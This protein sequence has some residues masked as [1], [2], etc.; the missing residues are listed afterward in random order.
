MLKRFLVYLSVFAVLFV[1]GLYTHQYYINKTQV[2]LIFSL[3]KV[4]LFHAVFS[5]LICGVFYL[6][7][8]KEKL[9][10]QLGFIYLAALVLKIVVFCAVFYNPILTTETLPK[11]NSVSLLIPIAIFLIAEVY[12]IA[13]ILNRK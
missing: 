1:L 5:F 10:Q 4:Y 8:Y 7:S 6:M 9:S 3:Q 11:S 2:A 12:F 13:N